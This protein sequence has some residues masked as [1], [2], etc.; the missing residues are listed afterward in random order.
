MPLAFIAMCTHCSAILLFTSCVTA[1][2]VV[3]LVR[4]SCFCLNPPCTQPYVDTCR[5][6][7]ASWQFLCLLC[8]FFSQNLL[9]F[10]LVFYQFHNVKSIKFEYCLTNHCIFPFHLTAVS[11]FLELV[12]Y[13]TTRTS[14][15]VRSS[16]GSVCSVS[17]VTIEPLP[18]H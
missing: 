17:M 1:V 13:M 18:R 4:F 2:L 14:G 12:I 7:H 11:T 3:S 16:Q 6:H 8:L 10:D 9:R 15:T 5:C